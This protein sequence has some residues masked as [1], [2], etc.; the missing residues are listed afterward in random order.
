MAR[1]SATGRCANSTV[2]SSGQEWHD[3]RVLPY[4]GVTLKGW[5][6]YRPGSSEPEHIPS[7]GERLL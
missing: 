6:W 5:V 7:L 1:L 2:D 4:V 3:A